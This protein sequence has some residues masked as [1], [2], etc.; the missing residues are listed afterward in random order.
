MFK[1]IKDLF[2]K[3]EQQPTGMML[4]DVP[5]WLDAEIKKIRETEETRVSASRE[6]VMTAISSLRKWSRNSARA[7]MKAPGL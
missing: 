7:I 5:G 1:K 6:P 3:E 2:S 4:S